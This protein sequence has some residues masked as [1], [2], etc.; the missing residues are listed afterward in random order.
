MVGLIVARLKQEGLL[1]ESISPDFLVRNWP[2]AL[3]EWTTKA[4]RDTFFASPQFPRLLDSEILRT[5]I[6][7]G[8]K[9]G[10]FGYVGK[11][12]GGYQGAPIIDEPNFGPANVEI[13]DQVVLLPRDK[14]AALKEAP[15]P[16]PG[17]PERSSHVAKEPGGK[18]EP[19]GASEPVS[20]TTPVLSMRRLSWEGELPSQKWTN[21]YMKVLSRFATD[22]SLRLRVRFEVAPEAGIT[23]TQLEEIEAA[24]QELG[25]GVEGLEVESDE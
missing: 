15:P 20:V 25:L 7:E 14:A 19:A 2:P 5:T 9:A 24:L 8:V 4:V 13:S 10:K 22:P 18:A 17:E 11:A 6:A 1:E 23:R 16:P 21:F 3:T 12:Y